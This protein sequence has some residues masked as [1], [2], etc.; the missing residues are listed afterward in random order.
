M[1]LFKIDVRPPSKARHF[2]GAQPGKSANGKERSQVEIRRCFLE[3]PG[4]HDDDFLSLEPEGVVRVLLG[5][6]SERG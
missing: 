4:L 6:L 3:Q 1:S 5:A 2:P